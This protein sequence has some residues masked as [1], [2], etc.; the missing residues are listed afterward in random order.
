MKVQTLVITLAVILMIVTGTFADVPSQINFQGTLTDSA[1]NPITDT[2]GRMQFSIYSDSV[3]GSTLWGGS[4]SDV[5][6]NEGLFR[7][8]LG[9]SNPLPS[10]LFDGSTL[11]LGIMI[12]PDG[13]DMYPRQPLV[14]V[15]YGFKAQT[16]D[17]AVTAD[18]ASYFGE[19][20]VPLHVTG[21]TMGTAIIWGTN[22]TETG[23]GV[24][25]E[26]AAGNYGYLGSESFGA[27]GEH[28][29]SGNFGY[30]GSSS[31]GAD[32]KHE[33]YNKYG[34]LGATWSIW[35]RFGLPKSWRT[36]PQSMGSIRSE[37]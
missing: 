16:A 7:V 30:L 27:Y 5:Q 12:T 26:N 3:G 34:L 6:V 1:G 37:Q 31:Y 25:G 28:E 9:E 36:R 24:K 33:S 35:Q 22:T 32:G 13:Q 20:A 2:I 4:H 29:S 21:D 11:W 18:T 8:I 23:M 15:P 19:F 17:H 14:T 10:T